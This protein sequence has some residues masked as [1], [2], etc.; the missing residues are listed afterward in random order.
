MSLEIKKCC[1]LCSFEAESEE[2]MEEHLEAK[3]QVM[4]KVDVGL[5]GGFILVD[6]SKI[7]VNNSIKVDIDATQKKL[8]QP[9]PSDSFKKPSILAN[10]LQR[11][12]ILS[13]KNSSSFSQY[14]ESFTPITSSSFYDAAMP[15][16]HL[17]TN[18][19]G[20]VTQSNKFNSCNLSINA[21]NSQHGF[22]GNCNFEYVLPENAQKGPE[23]TLLEFDDFDLNNN[24]DKLINSEAVDKVLNDFFFGTPFLQSNDVLLS[25]N[26]YLTHSTADAITLAGGSCTEEVELLDISHSYVSNTLSKQTII[27]LS[28]SSFTY[29]SQNTDDK[30]LN[31]YNDNTFFKSIFPAAHKLEDQSG[32]ING[33][34]HQSVSTSNL[35]LLNNGEALGSNQSYLGNVYHSEPSLFCNVCPFKCNINSVMEDHMDHHLPGNGAKF[36]CYMCPYFANTKMSVQIHLIEHHKLPEAKIEKNKLRNSRYNKLSL[37]H[38]QIDS[39]IETKPVSWRKKEVSV[40]PDCP[41]KTNRHKAFTLHRHCHTSSELLLKCLFCSFGTNSQSVLKTHTRLHKE[42]EYDNIKNSV[43]GEI[44]DFSIGNK[45]EQM[46]QFCCDSCP[47]VGESKFYFEM[48][49]REHLPTGGYPCPYCDF[50]TLDTKEFSHHLRNHGKRIKLNERDTSPS[51]KNQTKKRTYSDIYEDT[52]NEI[53]PFPEAALTN[54]HKSGLLRSSSEP[55]NSSGNNGESDG[56][57]QKVIETEVIKKLRGLTVDQAKALLDKI[58]LLT[59]N[60]SSQSS[61]QRKIGIVNPIKI[62]KLTLE[63]NVAIHEQTKGEVEMIK[64]DDVEE[65]CTVP[66]K[67]DPE[68]LKNMRYEDGRLFFPN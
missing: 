9:R 3:H 18:T 51:T 11:K 44:K 32:F 58:N 68:K 16:D 41:Y 2:V 47:W 24:D 53:S 40:C 1:E 55:D 67:E 43:H 21:A 33:A 64:M 6:D 25:S 28:N 26:N 61:G 35:P 34:T 38:L 12:T 14:K 57:I 20:L 27:P 52:S 36:R 65:E 56:L 10:L 54:E 4:K 62:L 8:Q 23:N 50:Q 13:S 42:S 15:M 7:P 46:K 49:S 17:N 45:K 31:S 5:F 30:I 59:Q 48:H 63:Q 37:S 60:S 19:E 66:S 29:P 39:S 22:Q